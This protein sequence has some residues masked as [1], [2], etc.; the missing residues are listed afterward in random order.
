MITFNKNYFY[1]K[2][3]NNRNIKYGFFSK[4]GGFSKDEY[5]SLNC[6]L[7]TEDD[8]SIVEKNIKIA[9]ESL[10]FKNHKIKFLKQ[11][12]SNKVETI[13]NNNLNLF[14]EADGSIT[15]NN[16]IA[17]AILTA[18]CAPVF[19][20][21]K[22]ETFICSL[23]IGWK[24]C[25][26]NIIQSSINKIQLMKLNS[27]ELVAIIGPCL[28]KNNFEVK[29]NFMTN[30]IS[31]NHSYKKFFLLEKNNKILFDMRGL[32]N[33]QL[34]NLNV[35]FI[36]NIDIDTYNNALF[37]SH[38]KSCH[39]NLPKTGRMINIIGFKS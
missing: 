10:G 21:D 39:E 26:K 8:K 14:I 5:Y 1:F 30:F 15:K 6:S 12:H 16:K 20:F 7:N 18:D 31:Q 22:N 9:K 28:D 32:I 37:F 27:S 3:F 4:L 13:D 24:G 17:L 23:H 35:K 38:R 29:K 19:I 11:V 36:Y 33:F 2:G 34:N 25:L